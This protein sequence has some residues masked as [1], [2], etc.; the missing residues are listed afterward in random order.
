MTKELSS[1][2]SIGLVL[3]GGGVRGMAH[4]GLIKA[5]QEFGI[6]AKSVTGSSVGALVGALYA[7]GNSIEDMLHFFK[8]TPLF[9][10]QFLTIAKAGFM[11]TDKY[12]RF[13]K[14]YFPED[15]FESLQKEL[16]IVATNIQDGNAEFFSTGELIRP[17]LASA[18]LPP[19]FSPIEVKGQLY[20]D[21]GIMNNFPAEPLY[22]KCTYIIGS[23]VSIVSKLEKK[24]L[25]NTY[26]LTGRVTGLMIYAASKTKL[27]SCDLLFE[28]PDLEHIGM[29]DRKAI[30]KAYTIGYE[31][32]CRQFEILSKA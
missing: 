27:K 8:T 6:E 3:S 1:N 26:Q 16:H 4:I 18:A 23:N 14:A 5:M 19:V 10:Y 15:S 28:S 30:E 22:E 11:D 24:D 21:G 25:K 2:K 12:I 29:L 20:V 9:N 31:H 32:A 13:F 7:N 17:L